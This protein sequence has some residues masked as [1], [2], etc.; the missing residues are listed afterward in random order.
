MA[1]FN[2][3]FTITA[4][5]SASIE[6]PNSVVREGSVQ[7]YI[8]DHIEGMIDKHSLSGIDTVLEDYSENSIDIGVDDYTRIRADDEDELDDDLTEFDIF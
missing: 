3:L 4:D 1:K 8:I 6:I 7:E 2:V 5:M